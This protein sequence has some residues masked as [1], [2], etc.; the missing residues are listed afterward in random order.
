MSNYHEK[1]L[2]TQG[3]EDTLKGKLKRVAGKVQT[4]FGQVTGNREMEMKGRAKQVEGTTQA[5][6]GRAERKVDDTLDRSR[7]NE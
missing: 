1:D 3:H 4:K 5:A 7:K 6:A 2:G